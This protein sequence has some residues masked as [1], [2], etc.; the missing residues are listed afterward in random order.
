MQI[1]LYK[2]KMGCHIQSQIQL[3]KRDPWRKIY[4]F[5]VS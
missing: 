4:I 5:T 2:K 3:R 1:I